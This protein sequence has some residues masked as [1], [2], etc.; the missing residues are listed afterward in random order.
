MSVCKVVYKNIFFNKYYSLHFV[1]IFRNRL[2]EYVMKKCTKLIGRNFLFIS[3]YRY[4]AEFYTIELYKIEKKSKIL[5]L[6][7]F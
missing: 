5:H 1:L 7:I 3:Y 4:I 2:I 6:E